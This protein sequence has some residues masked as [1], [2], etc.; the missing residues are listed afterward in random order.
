MVRLLLL[1]GSFGGAGAS[2]AALQGP[3][4]EQKSGSTSRKPT[5][6]HVS[7]VRRVSGPCRKYGVPTGFRSLCEWPG[8]PAVTRSGE[9]NTNLGDR[10][11]RPSLRQPAGPLLWPS[12]QASKSLDRL[13]RGLGVALV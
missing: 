13:G 9:I 11:R 7:R 5:R 12:A 4:K 10:Q 2:A 8:F 6:L 3:R 1:G